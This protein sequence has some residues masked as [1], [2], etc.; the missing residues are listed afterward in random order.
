MAATGIANVGEGLAGAANGYVQMV[1]PVVQSVG[2]MQGSA[3]YGQS[4]TARLN[5]LYYPPV[6][7]A[8]FQAV[9]GHPVMRVTTPVAGYCQTRGF[10]LA[11]AA[12][13]DDILA[14]NQAMDGG[15]FIE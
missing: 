7:D 15:V 3:A 14:V 2:T 11:A 8:G 9:Y 6:D 12:R 4:M 5:L 13:A 1:S 10:S